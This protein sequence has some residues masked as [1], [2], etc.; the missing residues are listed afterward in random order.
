MS[1][2]VECGCPSPSLYTEYSKG[3]I[4]LTQCKNCLKFADKY[5]EYDFTVVIIDLM[6]HRKQ[7]YRHLLYNRIQFNHVGVNVNILKLG[8]LLILFEV[9]IKLYHLERNQGN[10]ILLLSLDSFSEMVISYLYVLGLCSLGTSD[11][12]SDSYSCTISF[13]FANQTSAALILSSFEKLLLIL[14]VIWGYN[15]LEYSWVFSLLVVS[16]NVEGLSGTIY[17]SFAS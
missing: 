3:N 1:I 7:V 2:C 16:S 11:H 10:I 12:F 13:S 17:F 8:I 4:R 5:I 14:M 9:Y 15:R 6:L